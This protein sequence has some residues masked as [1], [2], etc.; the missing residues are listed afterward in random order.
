M[1][2]MFL[3]FQRNPQQYTDLMEACN[4]AVPIFHA[5]A[6]NAH[7]QHA[8]SPRQKVGFGLTDGENMER[9]W[10]YLGKFSR[11]TKEMS[12]ANRVDALSDAVLHYA[13]KKRA[14]LGERRFDLLKSM[15][16]IYI[17]VFRE[18]YCGTS[19]KST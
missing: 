19:K 10:S 8:Y 18:E 12:P 6:H 9:F 3:Y 7:C 16:G 1:Q 2:Y 13:S 5:Y 4:I 14:K 17:I 11:T 15:H